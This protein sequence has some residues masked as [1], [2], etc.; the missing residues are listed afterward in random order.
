MHYNLQIPACGPFKYIMDNPTLVA[1]I[2]MENS[3]RI[4]R[5]KHEQGVFD[6]DKDN[7]C[8]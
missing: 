6:T 1:F 2:R 8:T 3:I 7:L 5:A 4:Q